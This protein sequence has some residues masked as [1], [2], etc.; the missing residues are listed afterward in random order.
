MAGIT[1]TLPNINA[2]TT[3]AIIDCGGIDDG[4]K[5]F[6][7]LRYITTALETSDWSNPATMICANVPDIPSAPTASI[8][9]Q[10]LIIVD[11]LPPTFD[12]GSPILGY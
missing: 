7:Q 8:A 2:P 1:T 3:T 4:R 11:W 5:L 9:T 6:I 10:D 12:G